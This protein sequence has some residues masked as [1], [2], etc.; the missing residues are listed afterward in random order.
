MLKS[1]TGFTLGQSDSGERNQACEGR[2]ANKK[3][4]HAIILEAAGIAERLEEHFK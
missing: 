3:L 2:G 1:D 4:A